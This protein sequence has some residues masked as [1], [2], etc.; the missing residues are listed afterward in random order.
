MRRAV[1]LA[2]LLVLVFGPIVAAPETPTPTPE[3]TTPAT[4]RKVRTPY[5]GTILNIHRK[6]LDPAWGQVIQYRKYESKTFSDRERETIHEF[7]LQDN[8]RVVRIASF[9]ENAKGEGYWEV[10][11]WDLP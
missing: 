11:V 3:A 8:D 6:M 7:V 1:P 2:F 4:P 10:L 9:H 5:P